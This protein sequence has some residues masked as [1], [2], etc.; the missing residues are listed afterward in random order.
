MRAT[1]LNERNAVRRTPRAA[2]RW[3]PLQGAAR[4]VQAKAALSAADGSG[5]N[6]AGEPEASW[7]KRLANFTDAFWKFL[8]PH[9]IRG[10]V[11]ARR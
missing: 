10:T 1:Q 5:G 3:D 6:T 11:R 8:R 4:G 9:T 2:Q 7:G